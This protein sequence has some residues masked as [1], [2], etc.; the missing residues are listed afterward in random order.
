[1][2]P[3]PSTLWRAESSF[4]Q[5]TVS[6][7]FIVTGEGSKAKF[8]ILT[9]VPARVVVVDVVVVVLVVVVVVE[10]V[11]VVDVV[12]VVVVMEVVVVVVCS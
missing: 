10:V 7:R 2:K 12:V 1:M 9:T 5:V 8:L 3:M 11:V 4:T 6:P